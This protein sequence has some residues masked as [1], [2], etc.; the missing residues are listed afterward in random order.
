MPECVLAE[1]AVE[2]DQAVDRALEVGRVEAVERLGDGGRRRQHLA[3][4]RHD[5]AAGSGARPAR[6]R[7][8][9]RTP[10]SRTGSRRRPP[11][12]T[13]SRGCSRS[14]GRRRC[15]PRAPRTRGVSAPSS[16][17]IMNAA[18]L[19][20]RIRPGATTSAPK[21]TNAPTT[22]SRP[23]AAAITSSLKPFWS[24]TTKPSAREQR[25]HRGDRGRRVVGLHRQEHRVQ[26]PLEPVGRHGRRADGVLLDRA[27]DA[28]AVGVDRGDVLGV[29]VAQE[30]LVAV[31][32]RARRPRCRRSPPPR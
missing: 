14:G 11:S 8:T 19:P 15:R 1:R 25:R 20:R 2:L 24:E 4:E 21:L 7:S 5:R 17:P 12:T 28:Q 6:L 22:R 26:R 27:L 16:S 30:H 23:T 13:G 3:R 31:T 29:G 10:P 9:G 32:D 18:R